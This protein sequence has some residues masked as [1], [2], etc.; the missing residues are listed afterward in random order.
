[1]TDEKV[2]WVGPRKSDIEFVD[3]DFFY[4]SIT[5]FGDGKDNNY[6]F[7]SKDDQKRIDHNIKSEEADFFIRDKIIELIKEDDNSR[8]YFYNPN[9][10]YTIPGLREYANYFYCVNQDEQLM[11]DL[12]NKK[13]FYEWLEDKVCLLQHSFKFHR[14]N[15]DYISLL[16]AFHLPRDA[17]KRF[18]FQATVASGGS[19]TYV[20]SQDNIKD[21][22]RELTSDDYILSIYREH[23]IPV[24]IHAIIFDD[25]ILLSPGSIQIMKEGSN[26]LLYR[27][28]DFITYTTI[29]EKAR[30]QFE[31]EVLTACKVFQE[32]GFRGVCGIDG[33]ICK[34]EYDDDEILLL[35]INNRFQASSGLINAA[36]SK[37]G[38]PSLQ[39]LNYAAFTTGWKEEYRAL[40]DLK[41]EFSN[42]FYASI[43]SETP[44]EHIYDIAQKGVPSVVKIESDGYD[45]TQKQQSLAYLYRLVFNTNVTAIDA[46]GRLQVNENIQEPDTE[47]WL[48]KMVP[49]AYTTKMSSKERR[50]YFLRLKI[51][52]LVQGM[53]IDEDTKKVI[54]S[55]EGIRVATNNAVDLRIDMPWCD[56]KANRYLIINTPVDV[57]F[58]EFSP[59]TMKHEISGEGK[60]VYKLYYYGEFI[61]DVGIYPKDKLADEKAKDKNGKNI[62]YE[63][64]AFLSTDRLR[65]HITNKC[66]FKLRGQGC[67]FCN[68]VGKQGHINLEVTEKVVRDYCENAVGLEHFLVG[69]QTAEEEFDDDIIDVIKI[70]RRHARFAPIYAMLVPYDDAFI[71][72]MYDAGLT[73]LAFN[74][75]V[76]DDEI[77]KKWMPG[78]RDDKHTKEVYLKQLK[79]ATT[80]LGR[81]GNVRSMVIVGLE[82]EESLLEGIRELAEGGIQP[83]LSIFRPLP[84]TPMG[85][86][87]PPAMQFLFDIY[88]KIMD[89]CKQSNLRVGPECVNCQNNTL[90]LPKWLDE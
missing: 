79:F 70:I 5:L 10:A 77:A 60:T 28:A 12:R 88:G 22:L 85:Y 50:D 18:I 24:N 73:Q 32:K 87:N 33:I 39:Q 68:I 42:Y 90:A 48:N 66:R 83:I 51:A 21:V 36:C 37:A 30:L 71:R 46:N 31:E 55:E 69:G 14:E 23:N 38:L 59:F 76:F 8:F 9:I 16:K 11:T 3:K 63:E 72:R 13:K 49:I 62:P 29:P 82:P 15:C 74:I 4:G 84:D 53:V 75:E 47:T 7:C 1:M 57:K 81:R 6:A 56:G 61:T 43:G 58:V 45:K 27:G 17:Q 86:L 26:R 64:V 20:V 2:Y 54:D 25:E 35:E 67:K 44:I 78:K 19:G 34:D 40:K 41:V 89:I 52:M 80:L 65:V